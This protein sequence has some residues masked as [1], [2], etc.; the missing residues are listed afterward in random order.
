MNLNA[1][2]C[3]NV[4]EQ[5]TGI[6]LPP[7]PSFTTSDNEDE[8]NN[9]QDGDEDGLN[10]EPLSTP[11]SPF[12]S[13]QIYLDCHWTRIR[14][15][16]KQNSSVGGTM[17]PESMSPR[18]LVTP[19]IYNSPSESGSGSEYETGSSNDSDQGA[20]RVNR[21]Y[22]NDDDRMSVSS[23]S[24]NEGAKNTVATTIPAT[25][26]SIPYDYSSKKNFTFPTVKRGK[27]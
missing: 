6:K 23:L 20:D 18:A 11:P 12:L 2:S 26:F 8:T 17:A 19:S 7:I 13:E 1:E 5:V 22:G 21:P 25:P 14:S 24:S 10:S 9:D 15:L 16:K 3:N 4:V 27:V